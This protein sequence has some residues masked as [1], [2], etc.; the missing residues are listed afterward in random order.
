MI[1]EMLN[2]T[3]LVSFV[4]LSSSF[5]LF[6]QSITWITNLDEAKTLAQ[7]TGKP[8]MYDFTAKWC[9][10]CR[11][12]D[13]DFWPRA[14]VVELSNQ[15]V[16]V[17][18]DFDIEKAFAAKYGI[19]AIPNVVFTDPWGRGLLGQKGFGA[20]TDKEIFEKIK[21]LPKD[22]GP[23]RDAGKKLEADDKNVAALHQFAEFYQERKFFWLGNQ[24]YQQLLM[25]E[26]DPSKRESILLNLAF[27]H[28]RMDET[29]AAIGKLESLRTEYPNS[30]QNDMYL[31]GLIIAQ[32]RIKRQNATRLMGEL[33]KKFP[34]SKFI[35]PA[36]AL[37]GTEATR[38]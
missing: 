24:F 31:Y 33:K 35:G 15:F 4:L 29:E 36:E 9:G 32:N 19:K 28:I 22:F 12:M 38:K 37:L 34:Q 26:S 17:K 3:L 11:R 13:K 30:P 2:R 18:V 20:G 10:P 23:L 5:A 16:C 14:D 8:L 6:A 25:L 1:G 27:N 21:L 7:Q